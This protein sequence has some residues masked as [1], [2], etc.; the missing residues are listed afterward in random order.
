MRTKAGLLEQIDNAVATWDEL[1]AAAL[2]ADPN[3]PGA[4]GDWTFVDVAGHLN[5]WRARSVGRM[6]AAASGTEPPPPPWPEGMTNRT[7]EGIEEINRWFHEQYRDRPVAELLAEAQE[8][9]RRIRAAAE[10]VS[11]SDLLTTGHYPWLS[12]YP[13]SEVIVGEVEHF[14][15]EHEADLRQWLTESVE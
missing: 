5:G 12:G 6:E 4:M 13:L 3:R 14:H 9:W 11:E 10:I 2:R 15:D 7:D 8:Q 1:A